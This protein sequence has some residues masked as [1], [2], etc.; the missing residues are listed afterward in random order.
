M[1]VTI[2]K[3]ENLLTYKEF[4]KKIQ[5]LSFKKTKYSKKI[6][7]VGFGISKTS[8]HYKIVEY[9]KKSQVNIYFKLR[10]ITVRDVS[11]LI[12]GIDIYKKLHFTNGLLNSIIKDKIIK[13]KGKNIYNTQLVDFFSKDSI[14]KIV[15]YYGKHCTNCK[16]LVEESKISNIR[17]LSDIFQKKY[18][19]L[20]VL[21]P[22]CRVFSLS[23]NDNLFIKNE[24]S[25]KQTNTRKYY[26]HMDDVKKYLREE[27]GVTLFDTKDLICVNDYRKTNIKLFN[28]IKYAIKNNTIKI[29][30]YAYGKTQF[31]GLSPYIKK[32]ELHNLK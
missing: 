23:K 14:D 3:T 18:R 1:G 2:F 29:K 10:G 7:P 8:Q 22:R 17:G 25:E 16:N 20:N 26:Y 30:G 15:K 19:F 24:T 27:K 4:I 5:N 21:K 6:K 32:K 11:N 13:S 28:K 9:Y 12:S 31:S